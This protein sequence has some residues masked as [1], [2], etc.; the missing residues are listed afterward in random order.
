MSNYSEKMWLH[1]SGS[2]CSIDGN[3]RKT[4]KQ[5]DK[6]V[7][8]FPLRIEQGQLFISINGKRYAWHDGRQLHFS[9]VKIFEAS[10]I[11][12]ILG[13][14]KQTLVSTSWTSSKIYLCHKEL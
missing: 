9:D 5:N 14:N 2:V 7:H 4:L 13:M 12:R 11:H 10:S 3:D 8:T 1:N 6:P